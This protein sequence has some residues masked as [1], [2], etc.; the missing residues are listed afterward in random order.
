M[1]RAVPPG[2]PVYAPVSLYAAL[3]NREIV[4]SW[5][6]LGTRALEKDM[7]RRYGW[8]VLWPGGDPPG[9]RR[10]S[11]LAEVLASDPEFT[12]EACPEPF[13]LY[14]HR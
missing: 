11:A 5:D 6:A 3:A 1:L 13:L 9:E 4:G 2:V 7:R 12:A 8:I 14:R 10:D